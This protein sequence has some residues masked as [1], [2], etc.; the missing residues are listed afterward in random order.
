MNRTVKSCFAAGA[1]FAAL[2]LASAANAQSMSMQINEVGPVGG[3]FDIQVNGDTAGRPIIGTWQIVILFNPA[4]VELVG[5]PT[6]NAIEEIATLASITKQSSSL[7]TSGFAGGEH[8]AK[9][10]MGKSS[11]PVAYSGPGALFHFRLLPGVSSA[12]L[13]ISNQRYPDPAL[14]GSSRSRYTA[15]GVIY[16]ATFNPGRVTYVV[17]A[18]PAALA[19]VAGLPLLGVALRRRMR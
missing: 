16:P 13:E 7:L 6:D 15:A 4:E 14:P 8:G 12:V 19:F 17:P 10:L 1:A 3:E 11:T 18:P 5:D 9:M 2:A